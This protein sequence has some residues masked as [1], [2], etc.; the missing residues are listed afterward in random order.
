[1]AGLG[2]HLA[3]GHLRWRGG[4]LDPLSARLRLESLLGGLDLGS[5][6]LPPSAIL[7]I[8]RLHD[9]KPGT[10]SLDRHALR[11]P[12][13]WEQALA[14]SLRELARRASRPAVDFV[15][16]G[17]EAVVFADTAELLSCL[18]GDLGAGVAAGRW[19]WT[20]LYGQRDLLRVLVTEWRREP[21]LVP[22][23]LERLVVRGQ[24]EAFARCLGD[25][26]ARALREDVAR[27]FGGTARATAERVAVR[28]AASRRAQDRGGARVSEAP[29]RT[30]APELAHT[31]L[32][33]EQ[34]HLLGVALLVRRAQAL[35]LQPTVWQA[36]E[37]WHQ[38]VLGTATREPVRTSQEASAAFLHTEP[39]TQTPSAAPPSPSTPQALAWAASTERTPTPEAAPRPLTISTSRAP[40]QLAP[41]PPQDVLSP[42][43]GEVGQHL[44]P[45]GHRASIIAAPASQPPLEHHQSA[46]LPT[47]SVLVTRENI[48]ASSL[49]SST[50]PARDTAPPTPRA[51][52]SS[53]A[54]EQAATE[55]P[56]WSLLPI[57]T[58]LG[59][60]FYL[61][62]VGLFLELYGDFTQPAFPHLPLPLWDFIT[63]LGRRLLVDERP[64]D[65]VWKLLAML[66][67]RKPGE[68]PGHGFTP[69]DAWRL[70]PSWLRAFREPATCTWDVLEGRLRVNHPAGFLLLD[71]PREG[72]DP[73]H[74][75]QRETEPLL[76]A[77]P[78][79][80]VRGPLPAEPQGTTPLDRWVGWLATYVR[81][82]LARALGLS[83]DAT[84][85]LERTLLAH[86]ARVHVT[87]GH[88]DVL[89]PLAEL[90][91]SIRIAGLDRDLG[92][93]PAAG[94]NLQFHF[95]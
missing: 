90:P 54:P 51:A 95:E 28:S 48:S 34:T 72:D 13:A 75:V 68:A 67:G 87:D 18:A 30:W 82:R 57:P 41:P 21:E 46:A 44:E 93:I 6:G 71:V 50:Q 5:A 85:E 56:R 8:R 60:L 77:A 88:V 35:A 19:W 80:L 12:P 27:R 47:S 83:G 1:M 33:V 29:W 24:A 39:H 84:E 89:F 59:G 31:S 43:H 20:G 62:N 14:A 16:D 38:E 55:A 32:G 26:D 78:L 69:P 40:E 37:T 36:L 52:P 79:T 94:R 4:G 15:A 23:A 64:T 81:A 42:A 3:V 10:L 92:W 91:L 45:T 74:Q 9:P 61:A 11:P 65:P 86:E 58:G 7:C 70:P 17:A 2:N 49:A 66:S 76:R 53:W 63:L 73:E 25:E 22:A